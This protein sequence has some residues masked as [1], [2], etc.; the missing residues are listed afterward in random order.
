MA[1]TS[2]VLG[3]LA[4]VISV[5]IPAWGWLGAILGIVGIIL[6]A[7]GRKN[8]PEK[9]GLATAGLVMSIIAVALGLIFWIACVACISAA[10]TELAA[11]GAL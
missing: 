11:L 6:G 2:L 5:F 7:L 10:S 1:V 3:I 8:A 4:L 9:K